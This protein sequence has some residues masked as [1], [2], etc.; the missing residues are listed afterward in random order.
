MFLICVATDLIIV[1]RVFLP[2]D[3]LK[4]VTFFHSHAVLDATAFM[5]VSILSNF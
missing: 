5:S 4:L 2:K 1:S 3:V